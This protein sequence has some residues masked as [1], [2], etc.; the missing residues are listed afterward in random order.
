MRSSKGKT[1]RCDIFV[2]RL[3][4]SMYL[5]RFKCS[6]RINGNFLTLI[7]HHTQK[8]LYTLS[9]ETTASDRYTYNHYF[10]QTSS[11]PPAC[12]SKPHRSTFALHT[13]SPCW[14]SRAS[15]EWSTCWA[16]HQW[17]DRG[18]LRLYCS[19]VTTHH[20]YTHLYNVTLRAHYLVSRGNIQANDNCSNYVP[21][22]SW[23]TSSH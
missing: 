6:A 15:S 2:D 23:D 16:Q 7:L 8:I 14:R 4:W 20:P 19:P 1:T 13:V 18:N 3:N 11:G 5:N 9:S 10:I 17:K 22:H 21:S 12:C